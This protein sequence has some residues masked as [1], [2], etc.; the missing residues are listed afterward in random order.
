MP[1]PEYFQEEIDNL[2]ELIMDKDSPLKELKS[3]EE[4]Q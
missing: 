3:L 4:Y 2:V 1:Q